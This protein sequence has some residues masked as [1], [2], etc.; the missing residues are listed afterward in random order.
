MAGAYNVGESVRASLRDLALS[1]LGATTYAVTSNTSFREDLLPECPLIAL[2]AIVI[3][4]DSGRRVSSVSL[5][6]VDKRFWQFHQRA[7]DAPDRNQFLLSSD[8][9]RELTAKPGDNILVRVPRAS[10][11]PT[12]SLHGRKDDPGRT[13]R[14]VARGVL[15]RDAMGEF[16]LRPQQGAVR[17]IFVNLDRFQRDLELDGRVNV[18]LSRVNPETSVKTQATLDDLGLRLNHGVVEHASMMLDDANVTAIRKAD[19]QAQPVFTY[20]ANSIRING[21]EIPYSVVTA[22]DM[23]ELMADDQII[24]NDWAARDLKPKTGDTVTLEYY[25][26]DPSGKLITKTAAFK[27]VGEKP[28][29]EWQRYLTPEYPGI[30]DAPTISDW[31]PPFP[32]ELGRI[33]KVDEEYWDR[34]RATPKA[35]IRLSAGQNLWRS[36]YGSATG[37]RTTATAEAIRS[38]VDPRNTLRIE[39]VR[40]SALQASSGATDFG[41][42]FLD[43][44][45]FLV[46]SALLLA[47]MLFRFGIEQRMPQIAT[48][49]AVGWS[50]AS[51]RKLIF[52][53]SLLIAAVGSLIGSIAA[54]AYC[55]LILYA[56][57][58]WWVDA[59]GT[60]DLQM[61]F[62][63]VSIV[64]GIFGGLAM[65]IAVIYGA[66]RL[67]GKRAVRESAIRKTRAHVYAVVLAVVGLAMLFVGGA[68]GFFGAGTLLLAAMLTWIFSRLKRAAGAVRSVSTLG[69]R[70]PAHRPG[71]AVLCIALIAS[72]TFLIVAVDSF[73]REA[74]GSEQGYR[75]FA[76]SAI[77]IFHDPNTAEGRQ[78]LNLDIDAKWLAFRLRPGDDAS[79]LNLYQ[80][81]NPRVIGAPSSWITFD[82]QTDGAIPAA[83]DANTLQYVLHRKI[84]DTVTVGNARLKFVKALH[85]TVFQSEII[86]GD[87]EFQRAFPEEQGFRVFL[88]DA[89]PGADAQI[90][91]ALADYGIDAS[92][93][94]DR[95]AAF[96]RVE[97]TYLSTF[98]TLGALGLLLGT[99][100]L[101]AVILRNVLERRRELA[102]LRATGFDAG[103]LSRMILAENLFLL[104]AGL[105]A[106]AVT[107][108]IA[109]I[110]TILERGGTPPWKTLIA[111]LLVVGAVGLLTSLLAVRS[112]AREPILDAL[113]SE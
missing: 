2:D 96:H 19:P 16:S 102:L 53:E 62:S 91:T 7:V 27:Y 33:R 97:N 99:I 108:G 77:P 51:I 107:A 52:I 104:V 47:G 11:I 88:I 85:D 14:G 42:Y 101:G 37:M 100:G 31:D 83:V 71:R 26:W 110:P 1:R 28:I 60:R 75:Y 74:V 32:M 15:S 10:A 57:Q 5:Y 35:Y 30:S 106:G 18:A 49:R 90:E 65:A 44:S 6:A 48:L 40:A 61:V 22:M 21:R 113:R 13:V 79:C 4:D 84:G 20:L 111:L 86:I 55:K 93:V 56:L 50:V 25:L 94:A 58:T 68:G 67:I 8:L 69:I 98:Q 29:E 66:M 73:R 64:V 81:Q 17:A 63:P 112:T 87:A 76:E 23:S 72:A 9:A 80:P 82:A 34:Y 41:E 38:A 78:S 43:F 39:D 92:S 36:R 12:E 46:V 103:H 45:F 3:H 95:I 70:Y 105:A 54:F 24:L 109:V 89:P 59:V